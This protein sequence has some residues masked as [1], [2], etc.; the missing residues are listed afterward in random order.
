MD[1]ES[2]KSFLLPYGTI[3]KVFVL[4]DKKT[5]RHRS[6][7]GECDSDCR[8]RVRLRGHDR[9]GE[10][11]NRRSGPKLHVSRRSES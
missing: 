7:D 3:L 8:L 1:S 2:V 5:G 9:D 11:N 4:Y 10:P 6:G